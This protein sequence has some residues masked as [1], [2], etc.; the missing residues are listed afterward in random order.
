MKPKK[1]HPYIIKR[2]PHGS[3]ELIKTSWSEAMC[4][5]RVFMRVIQR[6]TSLL[7]AYINIFLYKSWF[8]TSNS[9]PVFC[10][11]LSSAC[12]SLLCSSPRWPI[13]HVLERH[14]GECA[15]YSYPKLKITVYN[16]LKMDIFRIESAQ[17]AFINPWI[18]NPIPGQFWV[19]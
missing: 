14:S 11:A 8:C 18:L 5:M 10:F 16:V 17:K 7:L 4:C 13:R 15:E 1:L 12:S 3:R 2:V 9:W 6:K 19:N